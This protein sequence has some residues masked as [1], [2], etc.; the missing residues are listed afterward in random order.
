MRNIMLFF[1]MILLQINVSAQEEVL[2]PRMVTKA[3]LG[4]SLPKKAKEYKSELPNII[5]ILADDMGYGDVSSYNPDA[6]IE[7]SNIDELASNGMRFTAAHTTSSV[8]TPSRYSLLTGR[9]NWRS[10]L[11]SGVLSAYSLPLIDSPRL[12]VADILKQKGYHTAVIGKWH[13]GLEYATKD[14]KKAYF[15]TESGNTNIEWEVPFPQSPNDLGF[16]YFYGVAASADMAPY[17]Y[18]ENRKFAGRY[19]TIKG[20]A[21]Y[22]NVNQEKFFRAGPASYSFDPTTILPHLKEK[23]VEYIQNQSTDNPFFLYF[24][25]T[26]PHTPVAPSKDFSGKSNLH[27]YLDFCLQVDH[28]VGEIITALKNK[29]LYNNTLVI[30]TSDNGF[31]PYVDVSFLENHG[32]YPSYIYRGY[33]ADIWEGGHRVPFIVQW[34]GHIK[35]QTIS[36]EVISQVDIFATF[37]EIVDITYPD[38]V[39]EDSYSILPVLLGTEYPQPL[40]EAT[41]YSSINGEFAIQR[42]DWKLILC[43]E[44]QAGGTWMPDKHLGANSLIHTPFMLYNLRLDPQEMINLYKRY[45]E[46]VAQLESLLISYIKKGRSTEGIAQD[47]DKVDSWNQIEAFLPNELSQNEKEQ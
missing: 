35:S 43:N 42:G 28:V 3:A 6:R 37:A 20:N 4:M 44:K 12:T 40:R 33:K 22:M 14:G 21:K 2:L 7:T 31:A 38:N 8:C 16:E 18:I 41:V 24:S 23:A 27:P 17:I 30:F 29:N 10:R 25:L 5:I 32:H 9:Y 1:S 13:L 46:K 36:E 11:K 34:P 15:S 47:N 19:D 45:P 39:G 26:A